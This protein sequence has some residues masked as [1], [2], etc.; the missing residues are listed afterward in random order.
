MSMRDQSGFTPN[1]PRPYSAIGGLFLVILL[2]SLLVIVYY[3]TIIASERLDPRVLTVGF[4][5]LALILIL[6][7]FRRTSSRLNN[8]SI[9][10]DAIGQGDYDARSEDNSHDALGRLSSS[11]NQMAEKISTSIKELEASQQKLE[12]SRTQLEDQNQELSLSVARQEMFGEFLSK[13]ASIEINIIAGS[14]IDYL[15]W[16]SNGQVGIFYLY[17]E[18]KDML[19]PLIRKSEDRSFL[20]QFSES[21]TMDGFAGEIVRRRE[22]IILDGIDLEALPDIN[23]DYTD[24][25]IRNIYGIPLIFRKKLLGVVILASQAK[26]D[27]STR[28][29]LSNHTE[30]L[31]NSIINAITYRAVHKQSVL[32]EDA[33]EELESSHR[34]KSEFVANMSHELRTPLNSII[35]F[36]GILMKNRKGNLKPADINRIEKVNDN[37]KHLLSLINDIL[38][39]AKI[40]AGRMDLLNENT[41]LIPIIR[42]VVEMF[43]AEATAKNIILKSEISDSTLPINTDKYKLRQVLSNLVGNAV[44]FTNEGSVI[45]RCNLLDADTQST[46]IDIIDTGIGIFLP[47]MLETIFDPFT[48][49]D[50]STSREFGGTGLGLTLSRDMVDLLGGKLTIDS[51][52]GKGSTFSIEFKGVVEDVDETPDEEAISDLETLAEGNGDSGDKNFREAADVVETLSLIDD[53]KSALKRFLPISPGKRILV[54]DDDSD[55]REFIGQYIRETGAE[56]KECENPLNFFT[57]VN[58]YKPDLIT[59][60]IMMPHINGLELLADLKKDPNTSHIP[61]IIISMVADRDKSKAISLGAVDALTKPVGEADFHACIRRSLNSDHIENRNILIVEDSQEYK[62]MIKFWLDTSKNEI[63]TVSNGR[64]ALDTLESFT[65][66]VIF[67]DLIMPVMDGLSFLKEFRAQEKF[68]NIPV[69]VLTAKNLSKDELKWIKTKADTIFTKGY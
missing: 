3:P 13:I 23:L 56:Y 48:Q 28:Q 31:A 25:N 9:I 6:N 37:G 4:V 42:D 35:G 53:S 65:P 1:E 16:I 15:M 43:Q 40:D 30:V 22:W 50:S 34:Q 38:D 44:K 11:V 46:R 10:S 29:H 2:F 59:L 54:V 21:E 47:E 14:A 64:E 60:D 20:S 17:E 58:E 49:A 33:N 36:S 27:K 24:T 62:E 67:L 52:Y 55:A 5:I 63:R 26:M 32:L 18:Q 19:I 66:D 39:L 61:V 41:D 57:L 8:L 69:I 68:T 51:E 45:V 7:Q 12:A